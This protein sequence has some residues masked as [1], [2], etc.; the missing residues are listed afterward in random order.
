M[1]KR[2]RSR[3]QQIVDLLVKKE[4]KAGQP[5]K[6]TLK[7]ARRHFKKISDV[8]GTIMRAARRMVIKK[9]LK[10]ENR[11]VYSLTNSGRMLF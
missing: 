9:L 2:T 6:F 4:K 5:V 7:V 3:S 1:K 8:N 10:R 11:G